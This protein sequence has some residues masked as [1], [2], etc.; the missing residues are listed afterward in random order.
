MAEPDSSTGTPSSA[1]ARPYYIAS[2]EGG[3]G[4]SVI[5][6]G[7]LHS[8]VAG[9]VRVGV[10]R[11]IV[12]STDEPDDVLEFLLKH[13]TASLDPSQCVGVTYERV[14]QDREAALGEIVARYNEVARQCDAMV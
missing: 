7:L 5:A 10:F 4:K 9:A 2:A 13:A 3:T 14:H 6:L 12:R 1:T 11:P 8:P